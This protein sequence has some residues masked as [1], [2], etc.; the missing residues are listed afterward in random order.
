MHNFYPSIALLLQKI[1]IPDV[2]EATQL[3][4]ERISGILKLKQ[5]DKDEDEPDSTTNFDKEMFVQL[6][7]LINDDSDSFDEDDYCGDKA[8]IAPPVEDNNFEKKNCWNCRAPRKL[9]VYLS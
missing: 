5:I 3:P 9:F 6:L 1:D 2:I 8:K 4:P 7:E